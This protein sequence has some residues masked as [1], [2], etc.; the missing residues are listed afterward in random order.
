[1][2]DQ[3]TGRVVALVDMDA[4]YSQVEVFHTVL[5]SEL[6]LSV[7]MEKMLKHKACMLQVQ[8]DLTRL[9]GKPVGVVQVG[10]SGTS[11]RRA[12]AGAAPRLPG[13]SGARVEQFAATWQ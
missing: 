8:R 4:F 2:T 1:M 3:P 12:P 13:G 9:A 6:L 5:L 7:L 10:T 11:P